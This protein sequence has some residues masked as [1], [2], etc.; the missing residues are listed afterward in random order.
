MSPDGNKAY[1]QPVYDDFYDAYFQELASGTL[2]RRWEGMDTII[3][4]L[5]AVTASG[6][7]V[8]GWALWT[9]PGF[10][11]VW[12]A[13][14]GVASLASIAHGVL[15]IP[16][17]V[18]EQ[19]E[20]RR[21]LSELRHKLETFWQQLKIGNVDDVS[22]K[23]DRLKQEFSEIISRTHQDLLFSDKL[24]HRIQDDLDNELRRKKYI[25]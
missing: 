25:D 13:I 17:R 14:A 10:K 24:R 8:A 18:K 16:T 15:R 22:G 7:A 12:I 4:F 3:T 1:M 19:E 20:L 6:S 5:V 21:Q 9:T 2:A 23:F 11:E